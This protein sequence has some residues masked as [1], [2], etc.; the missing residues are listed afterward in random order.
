[1]VIGYLPAGRQV[2]IWV[3]DNIMNE[4]IEEVRTKS[5]ALENVE[6]R[7]WAWLTAFLALSLILPIVPAQFV[8]GPMV[9]ALLI[10]ATVILGRKSAIMIALIPSPIAYLTGILSPVLLP[11]V[12]FIMISNII[13]IL[14][15][16][17]LRQKNYWYG[18]GLGSFTKFLWLTAAVHMMNALWF[19]NVLMDKILFAMSYFQLMTALL[20]GVIAYA[21]LKT[22]KKI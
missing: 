14:G 11:M 16:D 2:G 20:G 18:V 9:N 10:I 5:I 21:F 4:T 3:L 1:L 6:T 12:P 15:F 7:Y 22:I 19:S 17:A 8:S 13:L